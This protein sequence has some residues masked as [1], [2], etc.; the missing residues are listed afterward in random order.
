MNVA[1]P[2]FKATLSIEG[3]SVDA[4]AN[5]AVQYVVGNFGITLPQGQVTSRSFNNAVGQVGATY[6]YTIED[7][8]ATFAD[9]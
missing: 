4:P 5:A 8:A 2:P 1:K 6:S 7:V 3:S 9:V